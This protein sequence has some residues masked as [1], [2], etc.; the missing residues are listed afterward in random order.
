MN[1]KDFFLKNNKSGFKTKETFLIKNH[2][3]L[4]NDIIDFNSNLLSN[5]PFKQ[6]IWHFIN[7]VEKIPNCKNCNEPLKFGRSLNEGYG[8]FC[9]LS[10]TNKSEIHILKIK[11]TNN[12][13]Y[14]GNSPIS[15]DIIKEKIKN[16]NLIKYGFKNPFEDT[17]NIKNKVIEKLNVDHISKLDS[18]KN[19]IKE[20]NKNRYGVT[21]PL[22]LSTNRNKVNEIKNNLFVKKNSDYTFLTST[23]STLNVLCNS[24]SV[25][26]LIDRN[27]FNY[28]VINYI[29]PC[30]H[31]NPVNE[32]SSIKENELYEFIKSLGVNLIKNDRSILDGQ[33]LDIY[34]PD[35]NIA[36]EFNGLYYHSNLFKPNSYHLNKTNDCESQNIKLIHIF[37]DE[38]DNK[39]EIVKSRIKN[40]LKVNTD[41]IYARNCKI[42]LVKTSDKTEFLNDNHIQGSV[43]SSINIGLYYNDEL[44]SLMTFGFGRKIMNGDKNNYELLR[45]CNKINTSVVGSASKLLKHFI[46]DYKPKSIISY[47]DRRWSQGNIYEVLGFSK[48]RISPPN[49]FYIIN[50]K[51]EYRYKY[52]K[53]ILVKEGYDKDKTEQQIM[54]DRGILKIYD[55]GNIVYFKSLI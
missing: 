30:T 12:I 26:Y 34:L 35:H 10:C 33:E 47:A 46:E 54:K 42:S 3:E 52:R 29:N 19:K 22:I 9:S 7:N 27:V 16:T 28:R 21:T 38:W 55:S 24:C 43:G 25:D 8:E 31:C 2:I 45:F 17:E 18:T 1:Y 32:L 23:G 39:K 36:F 6:K 53:D 11:K 49:Y 51:R 15:S 20:T 14:G 40:L 50:K 41:R 37:E 48:I 13:K 5:I 4:Y 44:V